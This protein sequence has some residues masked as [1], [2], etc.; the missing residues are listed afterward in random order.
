MSKRE[1]P[2][3]QMVEH[4]LKVDNLTDYERRRLELV[5]H[6]GNYKANEDFIVETYDKY[7]MFGVEN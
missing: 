5:T 2:L 1:F 3:K 7:Y 6:K 4:I